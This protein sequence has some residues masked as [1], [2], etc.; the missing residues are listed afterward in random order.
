MSKFFIDLLSSLHVPSG[1][2]VSQMLDMLMMCQM[3]CMQLLRSDWWTC[4]K[5]VLMP[6]VGPADRWGRLIWPTVH[7]EC[8][9]HVSRAAQYFDPARPVYLC[10]LHMTFWSTPQYACG[11]G[12]V[13]CK[14]A[15][16]A[17]MAYVEMQMVNN[18]ADVLNTWGD[19][20]EEQD[21][22]QRI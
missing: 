11:S 20:M 2:V 5:A 18:N 17:V 12:F 15:C 16:L 13:L 9:V 3:A 7:E 6:A 21:I 19:S 8:H 22:H 10:S 14:L 1:P 4:F